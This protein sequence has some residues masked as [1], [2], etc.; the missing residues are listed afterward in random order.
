MSADWAKPFA[1][2]DHLAFGGDFVG[3]VDKLITAY[4]KAWE[5]GDIHRKDQV[6][7]LHTVRITSVYTHCV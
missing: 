1:D 3:S 7:P 4:R 6:T 5:P 2:A